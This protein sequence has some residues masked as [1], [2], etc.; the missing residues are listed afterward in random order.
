MDEFSAMKGGVWVTA[1]TQFAKQYFGAQGSSGVLKK[2]CF[3][4]NLSPIVFTNAFPM[5]IPNETVDKKAIRAELIDR[6]PSHINNLFSKELIKRVKLVVQHG[7]DSSE[8][9]ILAT[10]LIQEKCSELNLAYCSTAFFYNGNSAKIQ[11]SLETKS[12]TIKAIFDEFND[13]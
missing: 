8:P 13:Y 10:K 7:T 9:S 4:K 1:Y 5:G 12:S 11:T 2:L 3:E 6:V